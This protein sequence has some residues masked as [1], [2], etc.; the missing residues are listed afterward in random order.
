MFLGCK[1]DR[2]GFVTTEECIGLSRSVRGGPRTACLCCC[3]GLSNSVTSS[4]CHLQAGRHPVYTTDDQ[5]LHMPSMV[6]ARQ[7]APVTLASRQ[8]SILSPQ[9]SFGEGKG[10]ELSN[11]QKH[12]Q[13]TRPATMPNAVQMLQGPNAENGSSRIEEPSTSQTSSPTSLKEG[14]P[15]PWEELT[16]KARPPYQNEELGTTFSGLKLGL[17]ARVPSSVTIR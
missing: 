1:P 6:S 17:D 5:T 15:E 7:P 2:H 14:S 16:S 10:E 9:N 8:Q 12:K 4:S 11:R 3:L 13:E